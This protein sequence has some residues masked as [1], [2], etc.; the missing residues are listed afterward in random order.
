MQGRAEGDPFAQGLGPRKLGLANLVA[1]VV[2]RGLAIVAFNREDLLEDSLKTDVFPFRGRE[3]GLE[4]FQIR[5]VLNLDQIR[6]GD[7]LLD[8]T[9]V[10]SFNDFR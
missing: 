8:L 1:V 6:R 3:V 9:E 5:I 4:E 10:N 7:D 2:E